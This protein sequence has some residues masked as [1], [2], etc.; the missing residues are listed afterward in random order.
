MAAK[1]W[2]RAAAC[3]GTTARTAA[4]MNPNMALP[5]LVDLHAAHAISACARRC[6]TAS[7]RTMTGCAPAGPRC[8]TCMCTQR[9]SINGQPRQSVLNA[10]A[11]SA[12]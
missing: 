9:R 8:R 5:C 11:S 2:P 6:Q 1:A 3:S 7:W 12:L 4:V 10:D